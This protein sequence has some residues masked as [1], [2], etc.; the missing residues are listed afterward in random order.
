MKSNIEVILL[1]DVKQSVKNIE[2]NDHAVTTND[3]YLWLDTYEK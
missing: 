1:M 3:F 2:A